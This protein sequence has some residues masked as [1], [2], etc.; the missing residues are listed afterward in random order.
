MSILTEKSTHSL[1]DII[2][3]ECFKFYDK[4]RESKIE[5]YLRNG[6][7]RM[8]NE[9]TIYSSVVDTI[10]HVY[11]CQSPKGYYAATPGDFYMASEY[12]ST[13]EDLKTA[14]IVDFMN[15][16]YD[17]NSKKENVGGENNA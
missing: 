13:I 2:C 8:L 11:I 3:A 14:G 17:Q 4:N 16:V 6:I 12:F 9:N 7:S 5:S 10:G 15:G 1:N